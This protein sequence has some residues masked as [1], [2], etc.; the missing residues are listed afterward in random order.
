MLAQHARQQ[1]RQAQRRKPNLQPV[2]DT[3]C[4]HMCETSAEPRSLC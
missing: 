2:K 4:Q 3:E 1:L